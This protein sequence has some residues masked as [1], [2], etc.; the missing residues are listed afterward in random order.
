MTREHGGTGLGLPISKH[1]IEIHK[2]DIY[3]ESEVNKGSRFIFTLP[4]I[5]EQ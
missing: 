1:I 3:V 2:G 4:L 5:K